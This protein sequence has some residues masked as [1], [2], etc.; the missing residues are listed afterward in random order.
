MDSFELRWIELAGVRTLGV[1]LCCS[2]SCDLG[3]S[4][5]FQV[6]GGPGYFKRLGGI[7]PLPCQTPWPKTMCATLMWLS[8]ISPLSL[9]PLSPLLALLSCSLS[10]SLALCLSHRRSL[11]SSLSLSRSPSVSFF[12]L[13][14]YLLLS[15]TFLLL[16]LLLVCC[17]PCV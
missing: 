7:A 5:P 6:C 17:S 8:S 16:L 14:V 4:H 10:L 9:S 13:C 3:G 2:T 15:F 1:T 12:F 11:C